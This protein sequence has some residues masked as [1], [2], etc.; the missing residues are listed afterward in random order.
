MRQA[1]GGLS[2]VISGWLADSGGTRGK[3][4]EDTSPASLAP[5]EVEVTRR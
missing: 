3:W 4:I 1:E 5:I 2:H